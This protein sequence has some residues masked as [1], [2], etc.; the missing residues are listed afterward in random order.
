MRKLRTEGK[1]KKKKIRIARGTR[2]QRNW[3]RVRRKWK[4]SWDKQKT[5]LYKMKH[6]EIKTETLKKIQ[7]IQKEFP[8]GAIKTKQT[9][10]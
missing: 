6:G 2:K 9:Q 4:G 10:G 5:F 1:M 7:D 8:T 3:K